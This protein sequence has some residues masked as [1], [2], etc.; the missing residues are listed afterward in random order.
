MPISAGIPLSK[1]IPT[2]IIPLDKLSPS[3]ELL[4]LLDLILVTRYENEKISGSPPGDRIE[5]DLSIEK[6]TLWE[7][8]GLGGFSLVF[9]GAAGNMLT[10]GIELFAG[11]TKVKLGG[12]F[13]LRFPRDWM[14]PIV[15]ENGQ[16][17]DD[18]NNPYTEIA[19]GA[20]V[21]IDN[22]WNVSFEGTNEFTL[23]PSVIA[24]TGFVLEGTIAVDVSET[25]SLPE[26]MAMGLGESWRGVIFKS[27]TLHLPKDLN[28]PVL[29]NDL[30]L[31]NFH[32][33]SGGIS[34]A[35]S[36]TWNPQ[37]GPEGNSF[38]GSN[39]SSSGIGEIFGIP[40][41]LKEIDVELIQNSLVK[42]RLKGY[43]IF[44]FLDQPALVDIGLTAGGDFVIAL[45]A[46]QTELV[47]MLPPEAKPELNSEGLWVFTKENL[48][49]LTIKGL[50]FQRSQDKFLV[51]ISG[52]V[53]PLIYSDEL[54]WPELDVKSLSI[55]S[56]GHVSIDGGWIN[57]PKQKSFSLYGFTASF[58]KIG[59]GNEAGGRKWIGFSGGIKLVDGIPLNGSVEGLKISWKPP[60]NDIGLDI[61][62]IGVGF[63][64]KNVLTFDGQVAFINEPNKKGFKGGVKLVLVPLNGCSLDVQLMAGKNTAEPAYTFFYIAVDVQLPVG[65]PLA[66][67]GLALYG[68]AGLFGYNVEPTKSLPPH[69]NETWYE[70]YASAPEGV[71]Q[72][73]GV[74]GRDKWTDK[75]D[76]MAF[77]AGVTLG[78]L[79]DNGYTFA[80]KTMI[81]F[82]I[83]GPVII[84]E[85]KANFLRERASLTDKA[86]FKLLAVL[87][88]RVGTL[89]MN[90][91]VDFLYP[92]PDGKVLDINGLAE[93]F[94]D[95]HNSRNWHLYIGQREQ[96]KRIRAKILSIFE[97]NSYFMIDNNHL[98]MGAWIGYDKKWKFGPLRVT[99]GA[100][101]SGSTTVTFKPL[102]AEGEL[103]LHGQV[104][105]SV[106]KFTIE[107]EVNAGL[108]VK[109]PNPFRVYGVFEVKIKLP[110][111][112]ESKKA[113][114]ELEWKREGEPP[115]PLAL[116]NFGVEHLK[117]TEKWPVPERQLMKPYPSYD[118]D[119]DGFMD[120]SPVPEPA[121]ALIDSPLVPLDAKPVIIFAK[122]MED[123][124]WVGDNP[125]PA[126]AAEKIG[127]Y[128]YRYRLLGVT[129]Y[130]KPKSGGDWAPDNR[131]VFGKWQAVQ[132]G[133]QLVNTKLM[134]WARTPFDISRELDNNSSW[135]KCTLENVNGAIMTEA[136]FESI[137]F[138][139]QAADT[140]LSATFVE[141]DSIFLGVYPVKVLAYLAPKD[142]GTT[143][144]LLLS[145]NSSYVPAQLVS[146]LFKDYIGE[147]FTNYL[148]LEDM[149]FYLA[150]NKQITIDNVEKGG[151]FPILGG[152]L[153]V[154]I[155]ASV[156]V[157]ATF[158][159]LLP[160]TMTAYSGHT[161]VGSQE[162]IPPV[163]GEWGIST[164]LIKGSE[165]DEVIFA[166]RENYTAFI[167]EFSHILPEQQPLSTP[168]LKVV[169]PENV[170]D[171]HLYL[172]PDTRLTAT[173]YDDYLQAIASQNV[174]IP[175]GTMAGQPVT[176]SGN[177]RQVTL[178]GDGTLAMIKYVTIS[179]KQRAESHKELFQHIAEKT[180]EHWS[181]HE[182][183]LLEAD[184]YYKLQV[185]TETLRDDKT[186]KFSEYTYFQTGKPPGVYL[187]E[188]TSTEE[189]P[190][191][192]HKEDHYPQGGPLQDLSVYIERTI[193]ADGTKAVYCF[194]DIGLI[195][196]E[197]YVEQMYLQAGLSLHI[198]LYDN[199]DCPVTDL[200]GAVVEF[201]N[202]WGDNPQ[203]SL[204]R[205]EQQWVLTTNAQGY[206]NID[207][208]EKTKS[209]NL[210]AKGIALRPETLYKAKLVARVNSKQQYPLYQFSFISSKYADFVHQIHSFQNAVWSYGRLQG[211]SNNLLS[212]G[213]ESNL[214]MLLAGLDSN[215]AHYQPEI[216]ADR[217]E[218]LWQLF[219]LGRRE[220]PPNL[221]I[222]ALDDNQKSYGFLIESPE[223]ID[224]LRTSVTASYKNLNLLVEE[225]SSPLKIINASIDYQAFFSTD[226]HQEWVDILLQEDYN[227]SGLVIEHQ[228]VGRTEFEN[229]GALGLEKPLPGGTVIRVHTGGRDQD[230]APYPE[231]EHRYLGLNTWQF[232][233]NG[234]FIRVKDTAGKI[235]HTYF[236]AMKDYFA[237]KE[238]IFVRN[239]DN[240]RAFVFFPADGQKAASVS[241]GNY[242]LHFKFMRNLG[243]AAPILKRG[244]RDTP[245][246]AYIEFSYP[247]LLPNV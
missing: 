133:D 221:E 137:N 132:D 105:L 173:V 114:I 21:I 170:N 197:A 241:R 57:L 202:Q 2:D 179:E 101:I 238:A 74:G 82:L 103:M 245:E 17:L 63:E 129:L 25:A 153:Q 161:I 232:L 181:E 243:S 68:L 102:Q 183:N 174:D 189:E 100:W 54:D 130:K 73:G 123:G 34:G 242:R 246:E 43:I 99:L 220:L 126:P 138:E 19:V 18:P 240:T 205:E 110:W 78:T 146:V 143:R 163:Q 64:I 41:A 117:V 115:I 194:Y 227:I 213:E 15:Q 208:Q 141:N 3:G 113:K 48:L 109:T 11:T 237:A 168:S 27:L 112:L 149:I 37:L 83:P 200:D 229:Y 136:R 6:E 230:T 209:T 29:P 66:N 14:R 88:F 142:W 187:P 190:E 198:Q 69:E 70:W 84:V 217:F 188:T 234:E 7:V 44:P 24:D 166:N 32:I 72:L 45:T 210:S 235:L 167:M 148:K 13:R 156:Q 180:V 196:N 12:G 80:A 206:F 176:F 128:N 228:S 150:S 204:T 36:G 247:A 10:C 152:Q 77:G 214:E 42:S 211:V 28:V 158:Y 225:V 131:T 5:V 127:K 16:W 76:S 35:V 56:E 164:F 201:Q 20:A 106:F 231:A 223:P 226:Y 145:E 62:G 111:P 159:H 96:E 86:I 216:E 184:M 71:A 192:K 65:I 1:V 108:E 236:I 182:A 61:G 134:M 135:I 93:A 162:I 95:F 233:A 118:A 144:A 60:F 199:N 212:P 59:F 98:E 9:G 244:G 155:P 191:E 94:F 33:G 219:K 89:L 8:P 30:R 92:E 49:K 40:F 203:V 87:D 139:D 171:L 31:T 97:A 79:S 38:I 116:A 147:T 193:P 224:W 178:A 55:D 185:E 175:P 222:L 47:A 51:N 85:G 107:L 239:S 4:D 151:G 172:G 50:G 22:Q 81:V 67:T 120:A 165:I 121:N 91:H 23:N 124:A 53:K 160:V 207:Y 186:Y 46:D 195:Y 39:G 140:Y 26:T 215:G 125:Q 169:F 90:L 177:I 122:P 218:K 154:K 119:Q 52:A 104:G 157:E 75:Y 58:T